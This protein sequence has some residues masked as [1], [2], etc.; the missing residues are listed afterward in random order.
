MQPE[1]VPPRRGFLVRLT[2]AI[3]GAVGLLV[4]LASGLAVLVDPLRRRPG[5]DFTSFVR[6]AALSG[7]PEDGTPRRFAVI[8]D[9]RDAWTLAP[10]QRIGAVYLRRRPGTSEVQAFQTD[11][12][13]AGCFVGF[14]PDQ[15]RFE[16]P[17]H[18]SAFTLDGE[19]ISPSPSSRGMDQLK[20]QVSDDGQVLVE[21]KSFYSGIAEKIAKS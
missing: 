3:V 15:G 17:C 11:C 20:V 10:N 12:P 14:N 2:A 7:L 19:V 13:H 1:R 18:T 16:C 6:V 4:P 8:A 5:N 9:H 21:F